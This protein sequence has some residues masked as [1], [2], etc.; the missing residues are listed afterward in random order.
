MRQSILILFAFFICEKAFCQWTK[1]GIKQS[2]AL[3]MFYKGTLIGSPVPQS[4]I[5]EQDGVTSEQQLLERSFNANLGIAA[6]G[7]HRKDSIVVKDVKV[8]YIDFDFLNDNPQYKN[9]WFAY[10]G[11]RASEVTIYL[12][13]SQEANLKPKEILEATLKADVLKYIPLLDSIQFDYSNSKTT[14]I[15]IKNPKVYYLVQIAKL[16]KID[17]RSRRSFALAFNGEADNPTFTLSFPDKRT[18]TNYTAI[19]GLKTQPTIELALIKDQ[20]DKLQLVLNLDNDFAKANKLPNPYPLT[21]SNIGG[22]IT[23]FKILDKKLGVVNGDKIDC[24]IRIAI[25]GQKK[26][27]TSILFQNAAKMNGD[28]IYKTS[29]RYPYIKFKLNKVKE[30][31]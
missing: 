24:E 30:I 28:I 18:A 20:S 23:E 4:A 8:D 3:G 2:Q 10:K 5:K 7:L 14:A 12:S 11:L 17:S 29:L 6:F 22:G 26:D 15:T 9:I 21:G 1:L 16:Q 31:K 25:D 13:K 19:K 27:E